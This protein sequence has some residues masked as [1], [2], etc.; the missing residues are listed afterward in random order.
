MT[1]QELIK[2]I[3]G[4]LGI[5]QIDVAGVLDALAEEVANELRT[6]GKTEVPGICRMK[7][8]PRAARTGRNP[9]TGEMVHIPASKGVKFGVAAKLKDLSGI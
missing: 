1:K 9:R 4:R 7:V 8:A 3:A 2:R 6:E 5:P